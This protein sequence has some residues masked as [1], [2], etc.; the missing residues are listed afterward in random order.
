M[1]RDGHLKNKTPLTLL[2]RGLHLKMDRDGHLKNKT[3]LTLLLHHSCWEIDRGRHLRNK[4]CSVCAVAESTKQPA[5]EHTC[6]KNWTASSGAM[7]ADIIAEGFSC[8]ETMHGLRY[9][10]LVGDGDSN[11]MT[12]IIEQQAGC[13]GEF[14]T[15]L[16]LDHLKLK[17]T[18]HMK[19][20]KGNRFNILFE[21][22]AG[23]GDVDSGYESRDEWDTPEEDVWEED[24]DAAA[25]KGTERSGPYLRRT[26][27]IWRESWIRKTPRRMRWRRRLYDE[28][29]QVMN[30]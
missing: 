19:S 25:E 16:A 10:Y 4:F 12:K 18:T 11:T 20:F 2:V 8:S 6:F 15:Y 14:E 5:K 29:L 26:W 21:C 7:E 9:L 3:P 17:R 22:G 13:M 28:H 24:E 27:L 30:Q 23:D 1:D